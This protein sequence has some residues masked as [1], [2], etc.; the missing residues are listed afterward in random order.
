MR[1]WGTYGPMDPDGHAYA[2][3]AFPVDDLSDEAILELA[4]AMADAWSEE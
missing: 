1:H 4:R 2:W 3:Q